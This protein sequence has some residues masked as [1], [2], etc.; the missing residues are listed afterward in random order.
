MGTKFG[1]VERNLEN[2]VNWAQV[3]KGFSDML[4]AERDERKAKKG[5]LDDLMTETQDSLRNNAPIGYN[6][7]FN[8]RMIGL[9]ANSSAFVLAANKDLKA[10]RITP[11][12]YMRKLHRVNSSADTTFELANNFN[13]IYEDKLKRMD[14][15]TSGN[16][17]QAAFEAMSKLV[18]FNKHDFM[19]D[20]NGTI[21]AAPLI[22]GEDGITRLDADNARSVQAIFNLA[23]NTVDRLDVEGDVAESV[24]KLGVKVLGTSVAATYS[25]QGMDVLIEG[26]KLTDP[27]EYEKWKAATITRMMVDNLDVASILTDYS[28]DYETTT[29]E[30]EWAANKDKFIYVDIKNGKEIQI[31]ELT[32]EQKADAKNIL[33]GVIESQVGT[34]RTEKAES[35]QTYSPFELEKFKQMKDKTEAKNTVATYWNQ[36]GWGTAAQKQAAIESLMSNSYVRD[37]GVLGIE[38]NKD[39]TILSFLYEGGRKSRPIDLTKNYT[40]KEWASIGAE[41]HGEDNAEKAM[42]AGGGWKK[43]VTFTAATTGG[44]Q[45][46]VKGVIRQGVTT[47]RSTQEDN[48]TTSDNFIQAIGN[49]IVK[50]EGQ[51]IAEAIGAAGGNAKYNK[52]DKTITLGATDKSDGVTFDI[53]TDSGVNS[54]RKWI[55][56]F[57]KNDYDQMKIFSSDGK[58]Y[59]GVDAFGNPT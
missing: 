40:A 29:D 52:S 1:Y 16:V 15:K 36:L 2:D 34:S 35:K 30:K 31:G 7:D 54:V 13:A 6:T 27:K 20:Q 3:G 51:Q 12:E 24:K 37:G 44:S 11:E 59:V 26:I 39:G 18:D 17:E 14:D 57:I 4:I 8:D 25:K 33:D 58:K 50:N 53:T 48:V 5:A 23:Q 9:A 21:V 32:E 43:G 19:I 10:G 46:K 49:T 28:S 38:P 42:A 56:G 55:R 22:T 47:D 41:I 45:F